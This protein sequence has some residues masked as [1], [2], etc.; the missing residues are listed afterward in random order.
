MQ[1][2]GTALAEPQVVKL[3][4]A[5]SV[6]LASI[7]TQANTPTYEN[8]AVD[9][10]A[11][12][13]DANQTPGDGCDDHYQRERQAV[14]GNGIKEGEEEC[15]DGNRLDGDS[16]D[17]T[18]H[19]ERA[20]CCGNGRLDPDEECDDGNDDDNDGCS[21]GCKIDPMWPRSR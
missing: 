18:C 6:F 3:L 5:C 15:D 2:R 12:C 10:G 1:A 9:A 16:C 11:T 19:L 7:V 20:C 13:D 8:H 17:S 21:T 14:C 4:I